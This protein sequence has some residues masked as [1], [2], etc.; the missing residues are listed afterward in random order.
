MLLD[1]SPKYGRWLLC[2]LV[3][4]SILPAGCVRRRMTI[5]SNPAGAVAFVDDQEV[6][7]TPVSV[8]FTYY[9]TRKVQ[10]FHDGF[11]TLTVKQPFPSPWY[12]IPPLDF[13]FE[14]LW[15][16]EIRD[17]RILDFELPVQQPVPDETVIQRAEMLR[18]TTQ[19][20][21]V[22]PLPEAAIPG[23]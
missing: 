8:P 6:G 1:T 14:N 16:F 17:E 21:V 15:P 10:L 4:L 2:C 3:L 7:V 9:G 18:S 23:L 13:F 19:A 11:E 20:G 5:R 12:E 22:T